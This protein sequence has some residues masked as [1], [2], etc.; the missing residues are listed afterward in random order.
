MYIRPRKYIQP[1]RGTYP[2][3][4]KN[5]ETTITCTCACIYKHKYIIIH[6][7]T[8]V[9]CFFLIFIPNTVHSDFPTSAKAVS[10]LT[11][12][13]TRIYHCSTTGY[14]QNHCTHD[15]QCTCTCM[16]FIKRCL[17]TRLHMIAY[18]HGAHPGSVHEYVDGVW[19]NGCCLLKTRLTLAYILSSSKYPSPL[20]QCIHVHLGTDKYN[21]RPLC[22]I[23]HKIF[24]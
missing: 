4:C 15:L 3:H 13:C 10:L 1:P 14:M 9:N 6:V 23:G 11:C 20:Y 21:Y 2:I 22:V 5:H 16:N 17:G 12:V 7:H 18:T 19:G 24:Q 8:C